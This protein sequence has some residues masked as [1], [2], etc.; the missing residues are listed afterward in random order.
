M[1]G[2]DDASR[3]RTAL[4]SILRWPGG[5][6]ERCTVI[7]R[8]TIPGYVQALVEVEGKVEGTVVHVPE[9]WVTFMGM[10]WDG[11]ME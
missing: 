3:A 10:T 8:S 7:D 5:A 11:E 2:V 6:R 9:H 1:P 4:D